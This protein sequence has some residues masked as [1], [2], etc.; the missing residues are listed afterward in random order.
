[1]G[2]LVLPPSCPIPL[3]NLG[4]KKSSLSNMISL[5]AESLLHSNLMGI[6]P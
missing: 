5:Q 3:C 6:A 4:E 1:M 2:L